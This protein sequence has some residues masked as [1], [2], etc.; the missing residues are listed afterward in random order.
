[1][2]SFDLSHSHDY[3]DAQDIDTKISEAIRQL[4]FEKIGSNQACGC[5]PMRSLLN[6]AK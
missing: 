2:I 1:M 4:Q 5:I 3:K 6:T